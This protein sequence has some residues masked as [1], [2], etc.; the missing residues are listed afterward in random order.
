MSALPPAPAPP[1]SP[2]QLLYGA[3]LSRR[4]RRLAARAERLPRPVISIGNLAWGGSGKTPFTLALAERLTDGGRRVAVLSRGYGRASRGPLV[5]CRGAGPEVELA[6]AGD[7]PFEIAR[8]LPDVA[9]VV[10]ERRAE[11]GR[12]ALAEMA[13]APDLFLLDDGFSHAALARDLDLLLFPAADPWARGRLL[14]FGFLRE[15]L[16]ASARADAAIL[17]GA[18]EGDSAAGTT[19][20]RELARHGFRGEGFASATV[21]TAPRRTSGDELAPG[22]SVYAVA[23]IAR[24]ETF[25]A[26]ARAAGLVV[27]GSEGYRDHADYSDADLASI[28]SAA[29][30]RGA[31]CVL[32]TAKDRA[33][34]EGRLRFELAVLPI[35]ARPE[36]RFW[37]WLEGRLGELA[38]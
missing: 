38:R 22:T 25:F 23:A 37:S 5:V 31:A 15:P 1:R 24:P 29:G 27:V 33:K 9:I 13:P 14:P 3:L 20:A 32:T 17:T 19:L 2:W 18:S 4:A 6:D 30:K 11:A 10:A 12:L 35:E 26:A 7:E 36:P 34:L 16:A 21:A 8:A 28:A